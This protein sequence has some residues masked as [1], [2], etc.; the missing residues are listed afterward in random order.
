MPGSPALDAS[1][2]FH[3]SKKN[4]FVTLCRK[5]TA[6]LL[7]RPRCGL[8]SHQLPDLQAI[9]SL[10]SAENKEIKAARRMPPANTASAMWQTMSWTSIAYNLSPS[11]FSASTPSTLTRHS[12][13]GWGPGALPP[14]VTRRA[15]LGRIS[16]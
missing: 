3:K 6:E 12:F 2:R 15:P 1:T 13:R 4:S 7:A 5:S 9:I 16:L 10:S 11:F 14:E 8:V